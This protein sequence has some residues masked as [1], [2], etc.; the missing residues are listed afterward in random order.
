[1]AS[2]RYCFRLPV[3]L[4]RKIRRSNIRHP[5][6]YGAQSLFAQPITVSRNFVPGRFQSL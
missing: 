2:A 6:L 1:M 3:C 4:Y 5:K